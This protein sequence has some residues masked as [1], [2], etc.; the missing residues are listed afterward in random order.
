MG[1]AA[2]M[3]SEHDTGFDPSRYQEFR[4]AC[5]H[6]STEK[7]RIIPGIE[8]SCP[9]NDVHILTWGLTEFL[10][11]HQPVLDTL[12]RVKERGGVAIFAHPARRAA[13][14][15]FDENWVPYLTGIELW[16]RKSDGIS[17]CPEAWRLLE[18]HGIAATVGQ[19]FHRLRHFYPLTMRADI[20]AATED[21]LVKALRDGRMVP[22]VF[23]Q[24]LLSPTGTPRTGL[25]DRAEK[26]RRV[27]RDLRN[28]VS[29]RA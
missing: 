1:V 28:R 25:H 12:K 10:T 11:E 29:N 18:K 13:W 24:P 19:D 14:A 8:Y 5:D 23:G 17:Y 15:Q 7:C 22:H 26:L 2:V 27:L 9:N 4:K 16:N 21:Q 3:M 6:A 20:A